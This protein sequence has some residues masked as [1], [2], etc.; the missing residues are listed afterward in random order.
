MSYTP[1]PWKVLT[2]ERAKEMDLRGTKHHSY[3]GNE[4][5]EGLLRVVTR[6]KGSSSDD[7]QG[8]ANLH[9]VSAA[10]ELLEALK[11]VVAISDRKHDA[12]D[13]AHAAIAKAT[14]GDED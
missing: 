8:L 6:F 10:P 7:E 2:R 1:G 14:H 5:W 3:I 4:R 13:K 9:L 12:W 11:E